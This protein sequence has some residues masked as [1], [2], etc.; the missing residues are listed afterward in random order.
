MGTG[1]GRAVLARAAAEPTTLVVGIDA[2][3][4]G[5]AEASRRAARPRSKAGLENALFVVAAAE[6]LPMELARLA[7]LVTV[8]LPWGSLLRGCLGGDARVAAG[9]ASLLRAGGRLELL[10][11]PSERD[12]LAGLPL[13]VPEIE[14][15]VR[16]AFEP[17]GLEVEAVRPAASA[18]IEASRSTWARRLRRRDRRV[19]L[20]R[21]RSSR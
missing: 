10:L 5:M 12:R 17:F 1:D 8:I 3:A 2:N 6:D 7:E 16:R 14:G 18:E 9:L 21:L 19:V 13:S 20:A 15:S 11:A 4:A